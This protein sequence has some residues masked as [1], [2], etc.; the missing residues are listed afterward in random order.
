MPELPTGTVTFLFTDIEGSTRLLDELGPEAYAEA[1]AAHRRVVRDTIARHGG[2]EVDTQGD[3]FFVAFSDA[4]AAVT[5]AAEAQRGLADHHI[6]VRM[7]M[8][9]GTARLSDGG[10]VGGDVHLGARVTAA[11]HGGQILLSAA[12]RGLISHDAIDL[13]QHRLKDFDSPVT[14]YQ[15]GHERFPPLRTISNTNLPRPASPLVG[16]TR[17]IA[18]VTAHL[19]N[20]AR[21]LTLTGPGGMGKTRL[22]IES[23]SELVAKNR[24]GVFWVPLASLTDPALVMSEVAQTLGA[25]G[26][27]AEHVGA[28]EMLLLLDNFEHVVDAAPELGG[29]LQTCANLR[30]LV[31]S[32]ERLRV[33]GEVE[34][35]VPP[36]AEPEAVELF[37]ARSGIAN[38]GDVAELCRRLD[39]LPLAVE[40]AAARASVL[41]PAQM[42]ERLGQRLD[43][44]KGGRDAD[45]RQQTLRATIEWSHDL[46]NAEEQALFARLAVFHGG[47]TLE[48]AER[49]IDADIDTLQSLVDKSL[50]RHTRGRFWMLETIR[51]YASERLVASHEADLLA[52]R[53]AEHFQ[54]LAE[55]AE[56]PLDSTVDVRERW[57]DRLEADHENLRAAMDYFEAS[58]DLQGSMRIAGAIIE[59]WD[60]RGHQIE[61]KRRYERLLVSD[62][63]R[64][65]P[66]AKTLDG[67]AH[68]GAVLGDLA[69]AIRQQQEA[70][71]IYR[72]FGYERGIAL[73]MWGLGYYAAESGDLATAQPILHE[74][75][76]RL[77]RLGNETMV[78]WATRTLAFSYEEQGDYA[79]AREL[80]EQ[81]VE[82]ARKLG[83]I[84]LEATAL[85][86]LS[87]YAIDDER[88][89]EAAGFARG[90]LELALRISDRMMAASRLCAAANSLALLGRGSPAAALLGYAEV[91]Y[92][93]IGAKEPWTDR[94]NERTR[95][96]IQSLIGEQAFVEA[97]AHGRTLTREA[98][99][100]LGVAAL[101]EIE[102]RPDDA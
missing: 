79:R 2:V 95:A 37:T 30:L 13:G 4:N 25:K 20:G 40:L 100:A 35:A 73:A 3:A 54:A 21:L 51:E 36:L 70:L 99:V 58:G 64:T 59:F 74:V 49:V 22:A 23:A 88:H 97:T 87:T 11:G 75:V 82:R 19:Q 42:L 91:Q 63:A 78:G 46:L 26:P 5:A 84:P 6:R 8:H 14:I 34:Y 102:E 89:A 16:R 44:L 15:L 57:C 12:T 29:L 101:R 61:A 50:V 41:S 43:L 1:L 66:R 33:A 85:S 18:E 7:G 90:S 93:E 77:D 45:A 47:C 86:S 98:V 48:A 53:H 24:N 94:M 39:N 32:R 83:D 92:E 67:A 52:R 10:Y 56:E 62:A 80:H 71:D 31:T 76:E 38:D 17:E 96:V 27:V 81:N 68:M 72:E 69:A 9:T 65:I 60:E 55:E 28:N